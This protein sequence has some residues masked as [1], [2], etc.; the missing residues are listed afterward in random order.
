MRTINRLSVAVAVVIFIIAYTASGCKPKD[1]ENK[2]LKAKKEELQK[3][4]N[5]ADSLDKKIK[6]LEEDIAKLDSTFAIK[7]KLVA[8][9]AL[10]TQ[11]FTHNIDLQG[12]VDAENIAFVTPRGQGGQVRA[13]YVKQGDYVKKGQLLLKLDDA[14]IRQQ[15]DALKNQLTLAK[16]VYERRK[17]LWD[18]NIGTELDVLKSKNDMENLQ[19][20]IDIYNEQL[21]QT[22]VYAELSGV[23]DQV[24]IKQGEFFTPA[25]ASTVG[26]RIVN[27]SSLKAVV[28]VP[29][30]YLSKVKKG[31]PVIIEV[32]DVNKTYNSTISLISQLVSTNSRT[33]TAEAHLPADASLKPN[34]L[35]QIKIR[36]YAASKT[37]VV[38]MTTLQT[39]EHGKYVF[40]M[41]TDKDKKV[42]KKKYVEVG[43]VYGEKIE[44]KNGLQPGDQLI[45]EGYQGLYDNQPVVT[46]T[47]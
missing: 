16:T 25:S 30:N 46:E 42:A 24:T 31:A 29:E 5:S 36:D 13:I 39:D 11:D 23:A 10:T 17:N 35:A 2:D 43:E 33:F 18:Q 40:V 38:P 8:I 6:T 21:E 20:Q 7:P 28:E 32:P 45:S 27:T 44:V 47:K 37:I 12:K 4:K 22:S 15:I 14:V 34:Q 1:K 19:K 41:G 9:T 26:I 3:M